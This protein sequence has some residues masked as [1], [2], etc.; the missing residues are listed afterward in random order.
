MERCVLLFGYIACFILLPLQILCAL[1]YIVGRQFLNIPA[2]PLQELEWQLFT[3]C[4]FFVI[5]FAYLL[6]RHVRI[7]IVREKLGARKRAWIELMGFLVA[8]LPFCA[9]FIWQGSLEAWSAF[10]SGEHSRASMGLGYKW[11]I[12]ATVPLGALFLL[13]A[14]VVVFR[15]NVKLLRDQA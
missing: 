7:D 6:D 4:L 14:G 12:K 13:L 1:F 2:T 3:A 8:I 15:R 11:I 9:I 10:I 5:G